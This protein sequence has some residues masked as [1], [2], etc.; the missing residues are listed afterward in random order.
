MFSIPL[1]RP[2][3]EE[4]LKIND[5]IT[6]LAITFEQVTKQTV[7]LSLEDRNEP[8]TIIDYQS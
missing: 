6:L 5:Y 1:L 3:L 2:K 4:T 8:V 7:F